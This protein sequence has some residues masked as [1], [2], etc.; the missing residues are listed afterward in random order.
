MAPQALGP[1]VGSNGMKAAFLANHGFREGLDTGIGGTRGVPPQQRQGVPELAAIVKAIPCQG[2]PLHTGQV[3]ERQV[4]AE[5]KIV[6]GAGTESI[7]GLGD[8][9]PWRTRQ[10]FEPVDLQFRQSHEDQ[11]IESGRERMF[12]F[13]GQS[14]N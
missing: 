3:L 2:E 1:G 8:R 12:V 4:F 5:Q 13:A 7:A 11:A 9:A 10:A 14:E 6:G